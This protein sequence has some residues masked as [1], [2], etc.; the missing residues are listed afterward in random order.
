MIA[1][2]DAC[3]IARRTLE[4]SYNIVYPFC[5]DL[6]DFW[7]F[8]EYPRDEQERMWHTGCDVLKISK[9]TGAAE[10]V[11]IGLPGDDFFE[12][13]MDADKV[14]ISKYLEELTDD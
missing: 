3:R 9:A 12:E 10:Y 11:Y 5:S 13:L 6:G 2:R 1:L 8:S 4:N 14:D 7:A